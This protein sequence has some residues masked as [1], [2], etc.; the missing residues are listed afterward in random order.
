MTNTGKPETIR[1][2]PKRQ[3]KI[4]RRPAF[5]AQ[6]SLTDFPILC[7]HSLRKPMKE[8]IAKLVEEVPAYARR[9]IDLLTSPR[10][11][12]ARLDLESESA[13]KDAFTFLAVTFGL[14][15]IVELP[16][17]AQSQNKEALFGEI[18]V[19]SALG[20]VMN[21]LI[22]V[23]SW[24]LVGGQ[25]TLRRVVVY[26]CYF[27]SISTV[28]SLAC[29]LMGVAIFK[30]FDPAL[31]GQ[32]FDG[33]APDPVDL[34]KSSGYLWFWALFGIGLLLVFVWLFF[35]WG[36]YRELTGVS[37]LRSGI[38]FVIFV[39]LGLVSMT[40]QLLMAGSMSPA[41]KSVFPAKL[42]GDWEA[43]SV[44]Q[45]DGVETTQTATYHFVTA[46]YY[47]VVTARGS[48][49]GRCRNKLVDKSSGHATVE[50]ST[51]TLHVYQHMETIDDGCS[52]RKSQTPQTTENEVYQF[53]LQQRPE[54]Q[55]LCLTGRFGEQ[56]LMPK[57]P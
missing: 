55:R 18:A 45:S 17:V 54:G 39:V 57:H 49:N 52:G 29:T 4:H 30:G 34:M 27:A 51:L 37:K 36:A 44:S 47:T 35:V 6:N 10:R 41:S 31:A 46:G 24:R 8:L 1:F 15:F 26:S 3:T 50:G 42:V 53:A 28:I 20:F 14:C 43:R 16:L 22:L 9:F 12:V 48:N 2:A 25:I 21:L 56:C 5:G 13:L 23:L 11:Y 40:L 38:A 19:L 7:D 32:M 33:V